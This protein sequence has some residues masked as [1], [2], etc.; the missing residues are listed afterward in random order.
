MPNDAQTRRRVVMT[1]RVVVDEDVCGGVRDLL[2]E[3]ATRLSREQEPGFPGVGPID[4]MFE[5][6][7]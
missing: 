6:E 7:S 1:L 2:D 4:L 3:T 5:L